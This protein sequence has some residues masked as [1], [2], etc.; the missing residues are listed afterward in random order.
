[1]FYYNGL[2]AYYNESSTRNLFP[3]FVNMLELLSQVMVLHKP[4]ALIVFH[5]CGVITFKFYFLTTELN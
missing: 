5:K 4:E 2:D 3:N 1:M